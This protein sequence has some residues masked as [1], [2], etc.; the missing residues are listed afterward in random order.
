MCIQYSENLAEAP[1]QASEAS[2][3]PASLSFVLTYSDECGRDYVSH[4]S[5]VHAA[6]DPWNERVELGETFFAEVEDLAARDERAAFDAMQMAVTASSWSAEGWGEETGF[7]RRMAN[8]A[9][10]G[11]RA[12]RAGWSR[13]LSA[14]EGE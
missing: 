4:W 10:V 7:A 6:D 1:R 14:D 2:P 12:I 8:A 13:D 5:V 11:L 3:L 9:I